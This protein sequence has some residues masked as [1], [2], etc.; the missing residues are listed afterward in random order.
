MHLLNHSID[1]KHSRVASDNLVDNWELENFYF[2]YLSR[3][4]KDLSK[5]KEILALGVK[6][7][8]RGCLRCCMH[9][10]TDRVVATGC[11]LR[12]HPTEMDMQDMNRLVQSDLNAQYL[13]GEVCERKPHFARFFFYTYENVFLS[14][15]DACRKATIAWL[16]LSKMFLTRDMRNYIAKII[17]QTRSEATCWL[18]SK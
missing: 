13:V 15:N 14:S 7:S 8:V 16:L 1:Q 6:Q 11:G 10:F 2:H 18:K 12:I 9:D 3:G 5:A 17:W 4:N